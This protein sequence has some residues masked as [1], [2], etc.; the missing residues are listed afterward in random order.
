M[1]TK[2]YIFIPF[3]VSVLALAGCSGEP[4]ANDIEKL[5]MEDLERQ[6]AQL[7]AMG[8]GQ[9]SEALKASIHSV[10]KIACEG[11]DKTYIC[12]VEVDASA[13]GMR[14]KSVSQMRIVKGSDGWMISR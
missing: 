6:N 1:N 8:A 11:E 7:Q 4:S 3:V 13:M 10:K 9:F 2:K 14:D 12:D 5:I